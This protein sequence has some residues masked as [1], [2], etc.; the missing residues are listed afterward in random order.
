MNSFPPLDLG[1]QKISQGRLC[2]RDLTS[3]YLLASR[4]NLHMHKRHR[5]LFLSHSRFVNCNPQANDLSMFDGLADDVLGVT[6]Q[7]LSTQ[8]QHTYPC[9]VGHHIVIVH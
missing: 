5:I 6:Q 2:A 4:A 8:G 3:G 9:I 1:A 7:R